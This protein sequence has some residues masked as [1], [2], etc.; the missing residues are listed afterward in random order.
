MDNLYFLGD[1]HSS[2]S[3]IAHSDQ[4]T[5]CIRLTPEAIEL[6][7]EFNRSGSFPSFALR[8]ETSI[9]NPDMDCMEKVGINASELNQE[10]CFLE[11]HRYFFQREF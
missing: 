7:L 10:S 6:I 8:Y 9:P 11:D 4:K 2:H 3:L 1:G 5:S